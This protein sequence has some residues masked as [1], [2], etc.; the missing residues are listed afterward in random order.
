MKDWLVVD[1]CD[2]YNKTTRMN[3]SSLKKV[4]NIV[5]EEEENPIISCIKHLSKLIMLREKNES[6]TKQGL[7]I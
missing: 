1:T 5:E 2:T 7:K 6:N 4:L 3:F